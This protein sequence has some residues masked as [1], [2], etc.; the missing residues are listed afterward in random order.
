MVIYMNNRL[1]DDVYFIRQI[2]EL[3]SRLAEINNDIIELTL[4]RNKHL[5]DL[6]M[7]YNKNRDILVFDDLFCRLRNDPK[8]AKDVKGIVIK[9][10]DQL[11]GIQKAGARSARY[12]EEN[13]IKL[14]LLLGSKAVIY[15]M[16]AT[17]FNDIMQDLVDG[18]D[19]HE[20]EI[21][22]NRITN[23]RNNLHIMGINKTYS[24]TKI[25]L[26][27]GTSYIQEIVTLILTSIAMKLYSLDIEDYIGR[28]LEEYL[29]QVKSE[30]LRDTLGRIT[31][32]G[33]LIA[34]CG[35][36]LIEVLKYDWR[37][38]ERNCMYPFGEINDTLDIGLK[39]FKY[40]EK[41]QSK[42]DLINTQ[43]WPRDQSISLHA[44]AILKLAIGYYNADHKSR[45]EQS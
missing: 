27:L 25:N 43:P 31:D 12:K 23:I 2:L 40:S 44:I 21:T 24:T 22:Y 14:H 3:H 18:F 34:H 42:Y 20:L 15:Y 45:E 7:G 17:D 13:C 38:L 32:E 10:Y 6:D 35:N 4:P 30:K 11:I 5:I 39:Q 36:I 33:G 8:L 29:N 28:A 9:C 37:W 19:I 1:R 41:I 26:N 16:D